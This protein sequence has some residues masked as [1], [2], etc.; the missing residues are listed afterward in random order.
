M[1][2]T[3]AQ[4]EYLAFKARCLKETRPGTLNGGREVLFIYMEG[5]EAGWMPP[6]TNEAPP[7]PQRS[8][9]RRRGKLAQLKARTAKATPKKLVLSEAEQRELEQRYDAI[10]TVVRDIIKAE[11][12]AGTLAKLMERLRPNVTL[13]K[14]VLPRAIELILASPNAD[15]QYAHKDYVESTQVQVAL[16]RHVG[17]GPVRRHY[18]RARAMQ[19]QLYVN[20]AAHATTLVTFKGSAIGAQRAAYEATTG[21][22]PTMAW[23]ADANIVAELAAV[24]EADDDDL[25]T[26]S[27]SWGAVPA[28]QWQAIGDHGAVHYGPATDTLRVILVLVLTVESH[29]GWAPLQYAGPPALL[30]LGNA[31]GLVRAKVVEEVAT[32]YLANRCKEEGDEYEPHFARLGLLRRTYADAG[33]RGDQLDAEDLET[34]D[35]PDFAPWLQQ[36][37][38]AVWA[39]YTVQQWPPEYVA[40]FIAY[41]THHGGIIRGDVQMPEDYVRNFVS[42]DSNSRAHCRRVDRLPVDVQLWTHTWEPVFNAACKGTDDCSCATCT[43]A[44]ADGYKPDASG[45]QEDTIG[46]FFKW[47]TNA[48][49]LPDVKA[50]VFHVPRSSEAGFVLIDKTGKKLEISPGECG[51]LCE[52]F[53]GVIRWRKGARVL[54]RYDYVDMYSEPHS[55]TVTCDEC[56]LGCAAEHYRHTEA[57]GRECS[58]MKLEELK[59]VCR[60]LR[61]TV[62]GRKD[63]LQERIRAWNKEQNSTNTLLLPSECRDLC[64]V[65]YLKKGPA[66]AIERAVGAQKVTRNRHDTEQTFSAAEQGRIRHFLQEATK[67]AVKHAAMKAA[68][69]AALLVS[70]ASA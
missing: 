24:C 4:N 70:D 55:N 15:A 12:D 9:R 13:G 68:R 67:E 23:D 29:D 3:E 25:H 44:G 48:Q 22:A 66:W 16:R 69:G 42:E 27:L 32:P 62:S 58:Q 31:P 56:G 35:A 60:E 41:V 8:R 37:L 59:T 43:A 1:P 45:V 10:A 64:R 57:A 28:G 51:E 5:R 17:S 47:R 18:P 52:G 20:G 54:K 39:D 63:E 61:L 50:E 19:V 30:L 49:L 21:A 33:G 7:K 46:P 14:T 38:A 2:L 65:C 6:W 53:D 26:R 34:P 11:R 40:A 36:L